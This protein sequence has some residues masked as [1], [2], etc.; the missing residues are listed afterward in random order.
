MFNLKK[1]HAA[2]FGLVLIIGSVSPVSATILGTPSPSPTSTDFVF[3]STNADNFNDDTN[4]VEL[5]SSASGSVELKFVN[6]NDFSAYFEYR[7]DNAA[8]T[9]STPHY[10]LQSFTGDDSLYPFYSV[11]ANSSLIETVSASSF[12]DVRH[13][14]GPEQNVHF[15]WTRFDV[16]AQAASVPEPGSLALLALGLAGLGYTRRKS[17]AQRQS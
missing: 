16:S 17:S 11:G 6:N 7:V 13:A 2:G 4:W 12:V 3:P 10:L 15:D 14:F 8:A 9:S 1:L 5:I